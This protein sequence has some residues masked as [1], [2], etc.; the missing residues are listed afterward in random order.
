VIESQIYGAVAL[1]YLPA[2]ARPE[3]RQAGS[4]DRKS[5]LKK[6]FKYVEVYLFLKTPP[7]QPH[8]GGSRS[9]HTEK[10][11]KKY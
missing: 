8:I 7:E 1:W 10:T 4:R 9:T 6:L 2:A 11:Q 5:T 3:R